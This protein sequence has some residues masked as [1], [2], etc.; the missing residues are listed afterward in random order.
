M[1]NTIQQVFV[2]MSSELLEEIENYKEEH[3]IKSRGKTIRL[4]LEEGLK[5]AQED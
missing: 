4:L 5:A 3:R 1:P 2:G